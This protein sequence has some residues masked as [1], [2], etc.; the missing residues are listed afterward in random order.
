MASGISHREWRVHRD[1]YADDQSFREAVQ[2]ELAM[3]ENIGERLGVAI[4]ATPARLKQGDSWFTRGW[5]FKTASVPA[6]PSDEVGGRFD[7]LPEANVTVPDSLPED[8]A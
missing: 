4:V 5:V 1:D 3:C 2:A 6:M 8:D 7:D